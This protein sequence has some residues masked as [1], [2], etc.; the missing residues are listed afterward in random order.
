[1][2]AVFFRRRPE[3]DLERPRNRPV[4]ALATVTVRR[5]DGAGGAKKAA[6]LP[7]D[8]LPLPSE[9]IAFAW[10]SMSCQGVSRETPCGT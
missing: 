10:I 3:T 2:A 5:F 1:M 9:M 7:V 8:R 4:T 6:A